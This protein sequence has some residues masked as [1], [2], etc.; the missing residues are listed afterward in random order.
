MDLDL[1][2][3]KELMRALKQFDVQELTI[4]REDWKLSLRR[5]PEEGAVP[6]GV[7]VGAPA[8][9]PPYTM[10]PSMAA[11]PP[12]PAAPAAAPGGGGAAPEAAE[13]DDPNVVFVTSPFVGTFYRAPS[14]NDPAFVDVG[15]KIQPGQT[16][17]IVEAMKLMNEI[18]SDLAG[19]IVAILVDNGKPVEYGDQLF[20]VRK[21]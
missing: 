15:D 4:E 1:K 6:T 9:V 8:S 16:L 19:T 14:P 20:K 7:A 13:E 5:G 11:A 2:Q 17:C 12:Q 21:G 3:L 18:E 10:P